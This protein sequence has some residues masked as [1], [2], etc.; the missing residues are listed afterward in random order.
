M[1]QDFIAAIDIGGTKIA[2]AIGTQK[3]EIVARSLLRTDVALSPDAV[4]SGLLE[5]LET[6]AGIEG[7]RL[8]AVGIG[9]PGPLDFERGG[10]PRAA[11]HA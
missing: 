11:E 1:V 2:V 3:G 9:C 6:L 4:V 7:G 10:L 5:T 8:A